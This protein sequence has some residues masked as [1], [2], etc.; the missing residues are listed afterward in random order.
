MEDFRSREGS[1]GK[2]SEQGVVWW[3]GPDLGP[4]KAHNSC[5]R[6][7]WARRRGEHTC[8]L[9]LC[10]LRQVVSFMFLVCEM[11]DG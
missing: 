6:L 3:V 8:P 2:P 9:C 7:A 10:D 5:P 11:R 4:G 1:A